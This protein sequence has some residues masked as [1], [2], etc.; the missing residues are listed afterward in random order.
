MHFFA[1]VAQI[2]DR[3]ICI[4]GDGGIIVVC[5]VRPLDSPDC[6]W[7]IE[8]PLDDNSVAFLDLRPGAT[9]FVCGRLAIDVR[10]AGGVHWC[11]FSITIDYVDV[12]DRGRGPISA[13]K[14]RSTRAPEAACVRRP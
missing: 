13:V 12:I 4:S 3:P 1:L 14:D 6:N 10:E 5:R 8:T 11:E 9:V 2:V 7:R